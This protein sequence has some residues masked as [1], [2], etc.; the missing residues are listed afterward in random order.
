MHYQ[1]YGVHIKSKSSNLDVNDKHSAQRTV[2]EI[3][4]PVAHA[5]DQPEAPRAVERPLLSDAAGHDGIIGPVTFDHSAWAI[6]CASQA[7]VA[8]RVIRSVL[9]LILWVSDAFTT[10]VK[11]PRGTTLRGLA[12]VF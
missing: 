9:A 1:R 8:P 4:R 7:T 10:T 11:A 3:R 2:I 5:I 6:V 12:I